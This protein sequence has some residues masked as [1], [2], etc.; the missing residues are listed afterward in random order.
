MKD[1]QKRL[2]LVLTY[3]LGSLFPAFLSQN[4]YMANINDSE[5][6]LRQTFTY[7]SHLVQHSPIFFQLA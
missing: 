7:I 1:E 5:A 2:K 3:S 4:I 6:M